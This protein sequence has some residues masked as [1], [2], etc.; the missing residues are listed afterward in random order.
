MKIIDTHTHLPGWSF[1]LKTR[2]IR[3]LRRE[4]EAEGLKGA[5]LFTTDGLIRDPARNN[6]ILAKAVANQRDF[7]TPFCGISNFVATAGRVIVI[8]ASRGENLRKKPEI[9]G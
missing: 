8:H 5:W 2:P 3:E 7:F 9:N 6:D 1:G 4:F